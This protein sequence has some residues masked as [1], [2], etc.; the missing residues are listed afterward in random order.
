MIAQTF[1]IA[2]ALCRKVI[3]TLITGCEPPSRVIRRPTIADVS[4]IDVQSA[5][6]VMHKRRAARWRV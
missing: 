5:R 6:L 2:P 4:L 3:L 1:D